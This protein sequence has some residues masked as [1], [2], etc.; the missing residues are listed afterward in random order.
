MLRLRSQ[1]IHRLGIPST[2]PSCLAAARPPVAARL[3]SSIASSQ[4]PVYTQ[5]NRFFTASTTLFDAETAKNSSD[6]PKSSTVASKKKPKKKK[7]AIPK[8]SAQ[9]DAP[10]AEVDQNQQ[11]AVLQGALTALK[12]VLE[13]QNINYDGAKTT[14]KGKK[15]SA[16]PPQPAKSKSERKPEQAPTEAAPAPT[17]ASPNKPSK[18]K[19]TKKKQSDAQAKPEETSSDGQDDALDAA[20][21]KYR[22]SPGGKKGRP[23]N[24]AT[25]RADLAK[26]LL[27]AKLARKAAAATKAE[28]PKK[29]EAA[30]KAETK[31]A[32]PGRKAVAKSRVKTPTEPEG[33]S[34]TQPLHIS[35]LNADELHL[36]PIDKPQPP[37]PCLSYGLERALFNPGVYNLQDPR[38]KVFNFDPYLANI[39]P[40]KEFDFDALKA[41]I[42]SSKDEALIGVAREH[43]KKYT[44]S[45]SSMTAALSHF[46]YLLSSWREINSGMMSQEFELPS[47]NFTNLLRSPAATFL[48]YKDGVYAIDADKE[49][50]S[51]NVLSMLGKSMEKLLT[52]PREEYERYRRENS[53][54]ISEEERNADEAY[55][56][57]GLGDFMMRSQLDAYDPRV[58][59]TGM[60][61][62]KTRAVV[63]IRM[64]V[65][66][67]TQGL[68][69]ELRHRQG[70]W[71]SYEREYHDMIRAAFL[72]YSLQVRMGRM[73]GIFVAFHNTQRIFGFQYIPIDEMDLSLHGTTDTTLGDKEFKL[74][75]SLFN[76]LLDRATEKF[77][78]QSL[79][80]FVE[81][82]TSANTPF[83]Y[84]F[85][86]PVTPEE[87]EAVQNTNKASAELVER[88]LLGLTDSMLDEADAAT[89]VEEKADAAET[90]EEQREN[91]LE[92]EEEEDDDDVVSW[93][94]I[95]VM[96]EDAME[97]DELGIGAVR[98]AIEDALEESGL[99]DVQSP[100]ESRAYVNALL[101]AVTGD[102]QEA[103]TEGI[104]QVDE[105]TSSA[106]ESEAVETEAVE[107]D[108]VEAGAVE[109][110]TAESNLV[111]SDTAESTQDEAKDQQTPSEEAA[112]ESAAEEVVGESE[113]KDAE[114]KDSTGESASPNM[115]TLSNAILR[116]TRKIDEKGSLEEEEP[117]AA[118]SSKLKNFEQILSKIISESREDDQGAEVKADED[119]A[120]VA[121][122]SPDKIAAEHAA[123]E[124]SAELAATEAADVEDEP[125]EQGPLLGMVLTV[126]NKVNDKYVTRPEN[127]TKDDV[128]D[129]EYNIEELPD[130]RAAR[131]FEQC[132]KRRKKAYKPEGRSRMWNTMFDGALPKYTEEGRAFRDRENEMAK[133]R[134][135]HVMGVEK[136]LKYQEV[137]GGDKKV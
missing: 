27:A 13:E 28:A 95:Q 80:L 117:D 98:Q 113:N 54:Q 65:K 50:D 61:D 38:S 47:K 59:G 134:P 33:P 21:E 101:S 104:D 103:A 132:K 100:E 126:R 5:R 109:T 55:H 116:M 97:D 6:D 123:D 105:E 102:S 25:R 89:E 39:M 18:P 63:S 74:S 79:R 56:Y 124:V 66:G 8:P 106:S 30:K 111:E 83:M 67:F 107:S 93:D 52:L 58:P 112:E 120:G 31:A 57:T 99:L 4:L 34:D 125:K 35:V 131:L 118:V 42:T 32:A 77:P 64:D 2:C 68:G 22:S 1:A 69:Y 17:A 70:N 45:T 7:K 91:E 96:V 53:H 82:R 119:A 16:K 87:I 3:R 92:E 121:S 76:K 84:A 81:T 78:K 49:F 19:K 114:S 15:K 48:H 86:K 62:L 37:V 41:Y 136:P 88:Q 127:L 20:L 130:E 135:V 36:V 129:I 108:A 122:E 12:K 24:R 43:G 44:G 90:L 72:K 73:D 11:L 29:A 10:P 110:E 51:A 14:T 71:E 26:G 60:F 40:I 137:F 75:L 133:N 85:M 9:K 46:H 128:W 115:S 23:P 94:E